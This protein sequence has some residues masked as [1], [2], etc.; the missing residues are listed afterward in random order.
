M[1]DDFDRFSF[2]RSYKPAA[3]AKISVSLEILIQNTKQAAAGAATCLY[4]YLST[5]RCWRRM[6]GA[7]TKAL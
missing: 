5:D 4:L 3:A 2:S 1:W 6:P 7:R